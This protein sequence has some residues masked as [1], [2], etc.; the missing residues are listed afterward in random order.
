MTD[1]TTQDDEAI[2]DAAPK[3][4]RGRGSS[5]SVRQWLEIT[6]LAK[7]GISPK[8]IAKLFKVTPATIYR[9]LKKR[10]VRVGAY[11][12][13]AKEIEQN[14]ARDRLVEKIRHTREE[15]YK[16]TEALQQLVLTTL[17][18]A[19][20]DNKPYSTVQDD[21]RTLNTAIQA[22]RAGTDNKWRILGLDREN[23]DADR[24]LPE[25]PVRELTDIEVEAIRDQQ[26]LE[27][28]DDDPDAIDD[29]I[30]DETVEEGDEDDDLDDEDEDEEP[31]DEDDGRVGGD[32][33]KL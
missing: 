18:K 21:I 28:I 15:D 32:D 11:V 6:G 31:E 14:T 7:E 13:S 26:E 24:T 2:L 1:D 22:I 25:L 4:K 5:L 9:G 20:Q 17:L 27:D 23:E 29:L 16:R 8:K 10:G 12:A 19:R 3:R 33:G 30:E